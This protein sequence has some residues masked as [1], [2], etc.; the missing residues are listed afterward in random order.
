MVAYI[1]NNFKI[2][3]N[4]CCKIWHPPLLLCSFSWRWWLYFCFAYSCCGIIRS[5]QPECYKQSGLHHLT[6]N[7]Q[8]YYQ[9]RKPS[10][11]TLPTQ[12]ERNTFSPLHR[13]K[14]ACKQH[15]KGSYCHISCA[16]CVAVIWSHHGCQ[17]G[18]REG[19]FYAMGCWWC[20]HSQ[21]RHEGC[22]CD[23]CSG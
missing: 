14:A 11:R 1:S 19:S 7:M 22:I 18:L 4:N 3:T 21:K 9:A 15:A 2:S 13:I 23:Q 10:Y 6:T 20:G 12:G 8:P 16:L 17:E 5:R